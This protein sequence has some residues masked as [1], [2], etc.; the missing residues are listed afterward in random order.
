M[1]S[2]ISEK[3][4][5]V[6]PLDQLEKASVPRSLALGQIQ[7][8]LRPSNVDPVEL[9]EVL[10]GVERLGFNPVSLYREASRG[11]RQAPP[12]FKVLPLRTISRHLQEGEE[13]QAPV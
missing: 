8:A 1:P 2:A 4:L 7:A 11:V 6:R 9:R 13:E 12:L 10:L 5:P 3:E